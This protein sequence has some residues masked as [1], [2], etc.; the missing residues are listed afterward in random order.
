MAGWT[1][2]LGESKEGHRLTRPKV[3]GWTA[4][5]KFWPGP[6]LAG[7]DSQRLSRIRAIPNGL[8]SLRNTRLCFLLRRV[9][10][11][12]Q[13]LGRR[14]VY[15]RRVGRER[16][17]RKQKKSKKVNKRT[18]QVDSRSKWGGMECWAYTRG[19]LSRVT[20]GINSNWRKSSVRSYAA[21]RSMSSSVH[22]RVSVIVERLI[23]KWHEIFGPHNIRV[24]RISNENIWC[25]E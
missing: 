4:R 21:V 5:A 15:V 3:E 18:K 6:Y 7:Q 20:G 8:G 17:E 11:A 12:R 14:N 2:A 1:F 19:A 10:P 25:P 13:S 22:R 9:Q 16:E 24:R 23:K